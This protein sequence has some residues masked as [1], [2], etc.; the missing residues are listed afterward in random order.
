LRASRR[1]WNTCPTASTGL[2]LKAEGVFAKEAADQGGRRLTRRRP[3][4]GPLSNPQVR[5]FNP[6]SGTLLDSFFAVDP[7]FTGGLYVAG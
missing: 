6:L 4:A 7:A 3:Q 1:T 2:C 5:I